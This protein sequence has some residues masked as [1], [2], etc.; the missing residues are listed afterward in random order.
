M[1]LPL[2]PLFKL[3]ARNWFPERACLLV[4]GRAEWVQAS[5]TMLVKKRV[6]RRGEFKLNFQ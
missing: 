2:F 1:A 6:S 4:A 5:V 3:G